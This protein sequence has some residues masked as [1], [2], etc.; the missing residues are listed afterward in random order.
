[1]NIDESE[2]PSV[3]VAKTCGCKNNRR[4]TYLFV[5]GYHSLCHN[6]KDI[7]IAEIE[8]CEKLLKYSRSSDEKE[9]V[10]REIDELK[11]MLDLI[12]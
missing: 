7:I 3:I 5:E 9:L 12:Q 1:M 8:A 2:V 4:V 11:T 10:Q 6:K